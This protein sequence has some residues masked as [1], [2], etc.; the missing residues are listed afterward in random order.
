LV[1]LDIGSWLS[2]N[3]PAAWALLG[4]LWWT[5]LRPSEL[6]IV[7]ILISLIVAVWDRRRVSSETDFAVNVT[8]DES[9]GTAT[10]SP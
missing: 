5:C 7:L 9:T 1:K 6:G 4:I 10:N 3:Q 2:R 8:S